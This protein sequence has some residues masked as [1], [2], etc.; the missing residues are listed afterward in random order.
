MQFTRLRLQGFKSFV[1]PA[2]LVIA[3]GLTGVVGPN[4]CGKSNL[5]EALSWVMGESRAR[6]LRGEDMDDVIFAGA[7]S[8]PA[9]GQASVEL[10]IDNRGRRAPA[11]FNADDVLEVSRR[12]TRDIGSA[13]A[14]NG[15]TVRARDVQMLFADAS[16]GA[17]SPSIVRQGQIGQLIAAKPKARRRILEEAAGIAGLYQRRHEAELKLRAAEGNLARVTDVVDGLDQQLKT[18]E[19][20]AAQARRYRKIAEDLRRAEAAALLRRWQG[21]A[22]R[23]RAAEAALSEALR[24]AAQAE[25]AAREAARARETAEGGFPP[26][27]EE[28]EI[29][30]AVL[31]RIAVERAQAEQ[32]LTEATARVAAL[33]EQA[34]A[35]ARDLARAGVIDADAGA[36]LTRIERELET[37]ARTAEGD[38]AREAEAEAARGA[39]ET[40]RAAAEG[41][42]GGETEAVATAA[43]AETA[44][45]SRL[46]AAEAARDA[47]LLAEGEAGE[48][49]RATGAALETAAAAAE[50]ARAELARAGDAEVRARADHE[51][52]EAARND[53]DALLATAKTVAAGAETRRTA[54]TAEAKALG[55]RLAG[56]RK[57]RPDGRPLIEVLQVAE[58]YETALAAALGDDLRR[59]ADPAP[60]ES[61]WHTPSTGEGPPLPD[62]AVPLSAH[63]TGA[64]GLGP[65]LAMTGVCT[66]EAAP[67]LAE[68]LAP[69]QRL[70]TPEGALWRWD[71]LALCPGETGASVAEELVLANRLRALEATTAEAEAAATIARAARDAAEGRARV[72]G[73]EARRAAERV[74]DAVRA[75]RNAADREAAAA[76]EETRLAGRRDTEGERLAARAEAR[77]EAEAAVATAAR[78]AAA[79]PDLTA[80]R[81]ALASARAHVAELRAAATAARS[82]YDEV[83][84]ARAGRERRARTLEGDKKSWRTRQAQ[85]A[86]RLAEL[87]RRI[88]ETDARLREAKAAPAEIWERLARLADHEREAKSRAQAAETA[89]AEAEAALRRSERAE[90]EAERLASEARERRAGRTAERDAAAEALAEAEDAVRAEFACP[91]EGV[92]NALG[93]DPAAIPETAEAD[94][95][96]LRRQRDALGAVNL[97]AEEDALQVTEERETLARE[98]ADLEAGIAKLRAG[99]QG[100]NREGRARLVAAFDAVNARFGT[101]FQHLF[102]GGEARLVMVE[103]EDPLDAGLEILCQPPGKKL[104]ALTLLSGGEQTLTALSLIFAVFLSNPAPICVLDEVDAPLDD[105]NVAR[106]CALL[107]EMVRRTETRFLIITHHAIT[108]SRMDRLFG[109]TMVERGVSQLVSVDLAAAA[110]LVEA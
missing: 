49:L 4:G 30:G 39:A 48:R 32:A 18:L 102:G 95:Q 44:V 17:Q 34:E 33:D 24:A 66:P 108:M 64:P 96:R 78:D 103:D 88:G 40:R 91:P 110:D 77:A 46:R 27:R 29:A 15:K 52:A 109:V 43:A 2:E 37:L 92:P 14:V 70:V 20:Q 74:K 81:E 1:D 53:A 60:G 107:D 26:L 56:L 22:S 12:I 61:G 101:L 75:A 94:V 23:Q 105:A 13:Y 62:G 86:G 3:D 85:A 72:A 71:G 79:L 16:T 19:R 98:V 87:E 90:R 5:L 83:T 25:A 63:V 99:I 50:A 76:R 9:K 68:A 8:R 6:A 67:G 51:A 38:S 69:G 106:F 35:L 100:L 31:Q 97:R 41:A 58:G 104:S 73:D 59:A 42:R 11:V 54:L 89:L 10:S 7:A 82:R 80:A 93:L 45:R 21:A 47:A 57:R 84:R 28:A 36:E 65:R 55:E